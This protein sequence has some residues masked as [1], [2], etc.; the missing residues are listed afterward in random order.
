VI[1][2]LLPLPFFKPLEHLDFGVGPDERFAA[3]LEL[4]ADKPALLLD[5]AQDN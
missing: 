5:R 1:F 2:E 3:K 4:L